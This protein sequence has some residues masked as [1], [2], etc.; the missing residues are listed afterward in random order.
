[1]VVEGWGVGFMR[2]HIRTKL[3]IIVIIRAD[4]RSDGVF[5]SFIFYDFFLFFFLKFYMLQAN[6]HMI[7]AVSHFFFFYFEQEVLQCSMDFLMEGN[8]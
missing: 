2:T 3:P 7:K 8:T 1:M 4:L 5:R 6:L